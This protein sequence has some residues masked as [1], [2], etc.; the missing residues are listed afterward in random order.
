MNVNLEEQ[1][2]MLRDSLER[3]L[4]KEY[5]F[6][7]RA[8]H[9]GGAQG[10][11]AKIWR[12]FAELGLLGL[13]FE[14]AHGGAGGSGVETMI[15]M[16]QLGKFLVLE[17]FLST[18]V[19]AGNAVR[20]AGSA[21]QQG[22]LLPAIV[23]GEL[24]MAFAHSEPQSRYDLAAVNATAVRARTA[25]WHLSG[26]KVGVLHGATARTLVVSARTS[27]LSPEPDGISL[28]LVDREAA[29]VTVKPYRTQDGSAAADIVF[30]QVEVANESVLGAVG[31]GFST[32]QHVAD[33]AVAALTAESVGAMRALQDMT[34]DYLKTRKQFGVALG[35][36]QALQHRAVDMFLALELSSS[37]AMYAATMSDQPDP[38]VRSRA[39]SAA[40]AHIGRS[41]RFVGQQAIQLHG[42]IGMTME[43]A[44]GHYVL[45]NM[46]IESQ[47]GDTHHH[48]SAF[49]KSAGDAPS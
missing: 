37:M 8:E 23:R 45:R 41:S 25:G 32:I 9:A 38:A 14:V 29:G 17:P 48:L 40:K 26:H 24:L 47:F 43:C 28:F 33:I 34:L 10:W 36:F 1:Q 5:S 3:F 7:Q 46:V 12:H 4:N 11:S 19:L 27:G 31:G 42:A 16:E 20:L 22:D 44:V 35:S 13:P 21:A 15:V 6:A 18:V 2:E 39:I 49:A 30:D